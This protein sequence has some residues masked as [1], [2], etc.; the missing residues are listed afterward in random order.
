MVVIERLHALRKTDLIL[1]EQGAQHVARVVLVQLS[2][3]QQ[4]DVAGCAHRRGDAQVPDLYDVLGSRLAVEDANLPSVRIRPVMGA[5]YESTVRGNVPPSHT[6]AA[7][8][9]HAIVPNGMSFSAIIARP[10][11]VS[12]CSALY[13]LVWS[14]ECRVPKC[15]SRAMLSGPGRSLWV[16]SGVVSIR[17]MVPRAMRSET[18]ATALSLWLIVPADSVPGR[19][20]PG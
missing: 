8:S 18:I 7:V 20:A 12:A 6:H 10:Y 13:A 9:A 4:R 14:S 3:R 15:V 16:S 1:L 17:G 19:V 2:R 5:G 11:R